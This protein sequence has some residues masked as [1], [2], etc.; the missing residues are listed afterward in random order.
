M[1][2]PI[3]NLPASVRQRLTDC[4]K[5]ENR[6]VD[7]LFQYF[8]M[9]RFLY[10]LSKSKYAKQFIL[11]GALMF[12]VWNAPY[13]RSTRDIDFLGYIKND[14]E[15]FTTIVK[16]ICLLD[17]EPDG[18]TFNVNS[19]T[20][21]RIKEDAEYEGIRVNFTGYLGNAK[22]PMQ[23]DIGFGDIV[24]IEAPDIIYPSL[25]DFPSPILRGYPRETVIAEKFQ[26]MA[27][28]GENNSR[29][30]DFYDIWLLANQ[31]EFEI[32]TLANAIQST[33]TNRKTPLTMDT[34]LFTEEF[35]LNSILQTRW[36]A[37]LN[38][39]KLNN[40]P[41]EFKIVMTTIKTFLEPVVRFCVSGKPLLSQRWLPLGHWKS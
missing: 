4:A 2:K 24:T 20:G 9:E 7:E 5:N 14:I 26:A 21:E 1:K 16:E 3:K 11:K 34:E 25:L 33:F 15:T 13:S 30:K 6:R 18:I 10:R 12:I 17:V 31:F 28:L 40:A 37:F 35:A 32:K 22:I 19:V 39:S 23:L 38:K 29:I 36:Q 8:A 27:D 41:S